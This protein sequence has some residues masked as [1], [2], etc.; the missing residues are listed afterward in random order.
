MRKLAKKSKSGAEVEFFIIDNS[1]RIVEDT[2]PVLKRVR[3]EAKHLG[4]MEESG[5]SI[6][7]IKS[8]PSINV[9]NPALELLK[10]IKKMIDV[11]ERD[12][13]TIFPM[14]SYPG[15]LRPETRKKKWY[16]IKG[17]VIGEER[18]L[19]EKIFAGFHYHYTL[20]RGTFDYKR[21]R[22]KAMGKSKYRD[23][24][25]DSYNLAIALDPAITCLTQS[26][27]FVAG[28]YFAKDSRVIL[29]RDGKAFGIEQALHY[30]LPLLG[31]LPRYEHNISDLMHLNEK[32]RDI[33][34]EEMIKNKLNEGDAQKETNLLR[35]NW[36]PVRINRLGTLELRGMDSNHPKNFIAAMVVLKF[37]FRSIQQEFIEVKANEIG[38]AKPFK[39]E[40]NVLYVPPYNIVYNE[41]QRDSAVGGLN[42]KKVLEYVKRFY[43]FAKK[44]VYPEYYKAIE[45]FNEMI[46][47]KRTMSDFLIKRV[48]KQG[49]SIK[50]TI[51]E[52]VMHEIV[53]KSSEKLFS[54]I[55]K[56]SKTIQNLG[57]V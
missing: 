52:E 18:Y 12:D 10:K 3:K 49:Y 25:I 35:F 41:L 11:I 9:R 31:G 43:D 32:R 47:E 37:I 46:K 13:L 40:D 23:S 45:P 24:L 6:L 2:D 16:V 27:P 30:N 56:T 38:E 8:Y 1:G 50:E 33:Y 57:S 17:K 53:I 26:S 29:Y 20:P 51:P 4:L 5:K 39:L 14:G 44:C 19:N 34:K 36:A 28:K 48:K 54:E 55:D 15:E 22:L 21:K 42:N 7:E